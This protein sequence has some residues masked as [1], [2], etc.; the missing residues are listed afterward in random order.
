MSGPAISLGYTVLLKQ[1]SHSEQAFEVYRIISFI[2]RL[3]QLN[4]EAAI[5][6]IIIVTIG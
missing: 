3:T 6:T 2:P 1:V 4:K 5:K